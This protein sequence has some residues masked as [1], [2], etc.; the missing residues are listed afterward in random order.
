MVLNEKKTAGPSGAGV[1]RPAGGTRSLPAFGGPRPARFSVK[2][3]MADNWSAVCWHKSPTVMIPAA[4]RQSTAGTVNSIS[5]RAIAKGF[6]E[7]LEEKAEGDRNRFDLKWFLSSSASPDFALVAKPSFAVRTNAK[8]PSLGTMYPGAVGPC[9]RIPPKHDCALHAMYGSESCA[10][11]C[12]SNN[13]ATP[14]LPVRIIGPAGSRLRDGLLD[15]GSDQTI[16]YPSVAAQ[17][18]V[19]LSQALEREVNLNHR[20]RLRSTCTL[21]AKTAKTPVFS[22][23]S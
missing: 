11:P 13:R 16:V 10:G 17:I 7:S 14:L 3:P 12:R 23:C 21:V 4:S 5:V 2:P 9:L 15:T 8:L 20:A 1:T 18:G 19:D 6:R 22:M